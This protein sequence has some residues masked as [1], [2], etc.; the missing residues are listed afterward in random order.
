[1]AIKE[2]TS[3]SKINTKTSSTT[4]TMAMMMIRTAVM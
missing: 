2:D 4:T 3:G 1:V